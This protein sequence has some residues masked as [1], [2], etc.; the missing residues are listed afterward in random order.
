MS[1]DAG[2]RGLLI[3]AGV[4]LAGCGHSEA[5]RGASVGELNRTVQSL[6]AQN[7]AYAKQVEELEN[8]VFIMSDQ[9]DSKKEAPP[10]RQSNPAL[11]K[12]TLHPAERASTTIVEEPA[13]DPS[14]VAV[15][16][17][18]DAAKTSAKRPMLRLYGDD[19]PVMSSVER[20][21][22]RRRGRSAC[23]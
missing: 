12:V 9:M 22:P 16:Y 8:R 3:V 15:E 13:D 19:V 2:K 18:G 14:E 1:F 4:A 5:E 7:T 21:P 10:P 11:P 17:A 20:E 6:R 23:W